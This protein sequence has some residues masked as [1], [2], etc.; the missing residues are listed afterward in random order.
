MYEFS[1]IADL[2]S[3]TTLNETPLNLLNN[4]EFM[5]QKYI[6]KIKEKHN[7]DIYRDYNSHLNKFRNDTNFIIKLMK[8]KPDMSLCLEIYKNIKGNRKFLYYLFHTYPFFFNHV[9]NGSFY[10]EKTI[11]L[12]KKY[13]LNKDLILYHSKFFFIDK[14]FI[15]NIYLKDKDI[16]FFKNKIYILKKF[17]KNNVNNYPLSIF[18]LQKSSFIYK[19]IKKNINNI[20][21]IK[22][23]GIKINCNAKFLYSPQ[24]VKSSIFKYINR[25]IQIIDVSYFLNNNKDKI[26]N[27]MIFTIY[28]P[29]IKNIS[30][31]KDIHLLKNYIMNNKIKKNPIKKIYIN[32][33]EDFNLNK[34][35]NID[36]I[37]IILE[38][39]K[40]K[41]Y[42]INN[43]NKKYH[44]DSKFIRKIIYY[45]HSIAL[46][47]FPNIFR[48]FISCN[49]KRVFG[50]NFS[51]NNITLFNK[52]NVSLELLRNIIKEKEENINYLNFKIRLDK[53]IF[54]ELL[55]TNNK[56]F[57]YF[58][59]Y[60]NDNDIVCQVL[61]LNENMIKYSDIKYI[62]E[63]VYCDLNIEKTLN[64]LKIKNF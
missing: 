30:M 62:N 56:I 49:K 21:Y 63:Y 23:Y 54:S 31:I 53:S 29:C 48:N 51:I 11:K 8:E 16:L 42:Y 57:S 18:K 24:I 36:D 40:Y 41:S 2:Y 64:N 1:K 43:I 19:Y 44:Y 10:N 14:K 9:V 50:K 60:Y 7:D 25:I 47:L 32:F 34:F 5:L 17:K 37:S 20:Y 38:I 59:S 52:N 22:K 39:L 46:L 33:L 3:R 26:Y 27:D 6:Q 35:D 13:L 45:N 4:E 28:K 58:Y 55:N 15:P 12:I 61:K